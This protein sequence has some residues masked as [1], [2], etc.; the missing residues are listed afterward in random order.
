MDGRVVSPTPIEDTL[1]LTSVESRLLAMEDRVYT[2]LRFP[3]DLPGLP[4]T[5]RACGAKHGHSREYEG[6][7]DCPRCLAVWAAHWRAIKAKW[8]E[9]H[10][11]CSGGIP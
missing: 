4:K 2:H 5:E 1:M 7:F 3:F 11:T 10:K 6:E 9:Y 8:A